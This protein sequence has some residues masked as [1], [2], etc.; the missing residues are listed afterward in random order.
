MQ[1]TLLTAFVATFFAVAAQAFPASPESGLDRSGDLLTRGT[2]SSQ[3]FCYLDT[4]LN[5]LN[6]AA[7]SNP[8]S[9]SDFKTLAQA[10]SQPL[11]YPRPSAEPCFTSTAPFSATNASLSSSQCAFVTSQRYNGTW[12]ADQPGSMQLPQWE[13]LFNMSQTCN[14]APTPGQKC[15]QANVNVLA[16]DAR[17]VKDVQ[18]AMNFARQH[19]LRTLIK[20]TGHEL[21]GRSSFQ[22]SLQ[23]WTHNW[24][25]MTF[26][27]AWRPTGGDGG[28]STESVVTI[29]PGVQWLELYTAAHAHGKMLVGGLSGQGSVGA[30]GGWVLGGGYNGALSGKLG[31]GVDNVLEF[32]VVTADG[33]AGVANAYLNSDLYWALRGGHA[34]VAIVTSVTYRVYPEAPLHSAVYVMNAATDAAYRASLLEIVKA[35]PALSAEGWS[36][37]EL[38]NAT[39]RDLTVAI[40]A[41]NGADFANKTLIPLF[42]RISAIP[43]VTTYYRANN[44][45]PT[46]YDFYYATFIAGPAS[47]IAELGTYA[48]IGSRLINDQL[49]TTSPGKIVD[50]AIAASKMNP[51]TPLIVNL[52]AGGKVKQVRDDAMALNPGWRHAYHHIIAAGSFDQ[53]GGFAAAD[54]QRQLVLRQVQMFDAI[55]PSTGGYINEANP[56]EPNWQK[57]FYGSNY[58]RLLSIKR[59]YD[60]TL[61]LI[62]FKNAGYENFT[63]CA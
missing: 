11:L 1:R 4:N 63:S 54:A 16:V 50:T 46:F 48:A 30:A 17:N 37:S 12:H 61:A 39:T 5:P 8:P 62:S 24:K 27:N 47:P 41:I 60:S 42:D 40:R 22:G 52:V 55:S 2:S 10:L 49:Y 14:Y 20:S 29:G 6:R 53:N 7:C 19:R 45:F 9:Q 43:G 13:N 32:G 44:T 56:L 38:W 25:G 15:T 31:L 3:C 51:G 21:V 35:T 23:I 59:K 57:T 33:Q 36:D 18:N 34:G 58:N 28:C 26:N